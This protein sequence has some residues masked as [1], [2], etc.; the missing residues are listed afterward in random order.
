[1]NQR[2]DN[3][4]QVV[5]L[6]CNLD[7][8]TGEELGYTLD[9]F[10]ERGAL[11]AWFVPIYMKKNRPA[12]LLS[13]L[14]RPEE[15]SALCQLLLTETSTLGVRWRPMNRQVADRETRTVET[16]WGMVR[17]KFKLLDGHIIS[18][19]PEHDDCARLARE[20]GVSLREIELAAQKA[21]NSTIRDD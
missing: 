9:L 5:L 8:M 13:V 3:E 14:C 16:P 17:C 11:D 18:S 19:K 20:H 2:N 15:A 21:A 7:D 10:L 12:V 1:M 6:E 4:D